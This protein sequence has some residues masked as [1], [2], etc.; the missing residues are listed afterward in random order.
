MRIL[1]G[2]FLGGRGCVLGGRDDK[3]WMSGASYDLEGVVGINENLMRKIL[4][5]IKACLMKG[6]LE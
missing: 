6:R 5:R 3:E 2:K 1:C 4:E